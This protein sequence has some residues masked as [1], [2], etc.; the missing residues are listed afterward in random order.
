ME[1]PPP[2]QYVGSGMDLTFQSFS[3]LDRNDWNVFG[4]GARPAWVNVMSV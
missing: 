1:A 4:Q 2:M 3:Q